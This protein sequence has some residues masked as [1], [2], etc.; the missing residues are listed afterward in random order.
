MF[1]GSLGTIWCL[2]YGLS[3]FHML[4]ILSHPSMLPLVSDQRLYL[5]MIQVLIAAVGS[6][7]RS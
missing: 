3:A 5:P 7:L 1:F 2:D 6:L 4:C